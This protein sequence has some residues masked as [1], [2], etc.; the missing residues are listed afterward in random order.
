MDGLY[1]VLRAKRVSV[2]LVPW[3]PGDFLEEEDLPELRRMTSWYTS[4]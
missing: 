3:E 4:G 2:H 1:S